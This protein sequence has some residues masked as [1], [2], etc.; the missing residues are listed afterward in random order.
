MAF[1][2]GFIFSKRSFTILEI[3]LLAASDRSDVWTDDVM[4]M[5]L[6]VH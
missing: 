3:S 1:V 4:D 2:V 6:S 5:P